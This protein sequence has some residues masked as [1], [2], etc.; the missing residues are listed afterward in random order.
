MPDAIDLAELARLADAPRGRK[1]KAEDQAVCVLDGAPAALTLTEDNIARVFAEQY[2]GKLLFDHTSGRWLQ[3]DGA[4]WGPEDTRLA[5]HYTRELTRGLN[6][7]GKARWAK[8]AVYGAVETIAGTDR[9]FA[10]TI[11]QFDLDPWVIG[12]PAGIINLK[13]GVLPPTEN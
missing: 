5:Y 9:V 1:A 12:T 2:G 3:W 7:E 6:A 13:T 4:R 8:A 11:G 10:R